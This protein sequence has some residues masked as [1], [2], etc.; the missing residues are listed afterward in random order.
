LARTSRIRTRP[1]SSRQT[2]SATN[3]HGYHLLRGLHRLRD[4]VLEKGLIT[5]EDTGGI[6]LLFGDGEAVLAMVHLIGKREKVGKLLSEGVRRASE[7]IKG[8][9]SFAIHVKGLEPPAYDPRA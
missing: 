5:K 1:L 6:E 4:G 7:K 3:T 8:S 9:E 2:G